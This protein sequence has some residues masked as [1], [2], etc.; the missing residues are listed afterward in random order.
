MP[1]VFTVKTIF[2]ILV[3]LIVIVIAGLYINNYLQRSKAAES[4]VDI[5][6]LPTNGNF[7][8]G[9]EKT[10][11]IIVQPQETDKKISGID[12]TFLA[13]G[14]I[15]I[16]DVKTPVSVPGGDSSI[17][18][19]VIKNIADKKARISYISQKPAAEL[20]HSVKIQL[21]YKGESVGGGK[22]SIDSTNT[23]IIGNVTTGYAFVLGTLEQGAFTFTAGITPSPT[24]PGPS[25]TPSPTTPGPS[26]TPSPTTP[27]PSVTPSP[28]TPGPSVTPSP[29]KVPTPI[30]TNT[31]VPTP[32]SG[33]DKYLIN[34]G[35][36]QSLTINIGGAG[37]S[38]Q[39]RFK[40]KLTATVNNP[41]LYFK[42]RVKDEVALMTAGPTPAT[43]DMCN[44]PPA[45]VTDFY[46][47]VKADG[48]GVYS[49]AQAISLVSPA[50]AKMASVSADGWVTLDGLMAGKYYTLNLKG[51]KTRS[52]K[53]VQHFTLQAGNSATQDFD[54]TANPL[55]PG[56][57]P[58]P[59][60]G[61]KQDCT[62]N[63]TDWSLIQSRIGATDQ[64]NLDVADV[65]Y[66]G[67]VNGE[68][69]GKMIHTLATK[70]DDD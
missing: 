5:A 60:N 11:D 28:T 58:D 22:I 25:V 61:G 65:D 42:L 3:A 18:T 17:F 36:K 27:G 16:L 44:N 62:V 4:K 53:M 21:S 55:D 35:D 38:P 23:T 24:T 37:T 2:L 49:P 34:V 19:Q 39:I 9:E 15:K 47:P 48:N 32:P 13:D 41:D 54:W 45:G 50:G 33:E 43:A 57:V 56:D 30:L 69:I 67:L 66:N 29:T 46:I 6:F 8:V 14:V 63:S 59:N 7:L 10:E 12:I 31:P 20:P 26:V 40:A 1:K 68:D 70:P 64:P 51:P 52:V